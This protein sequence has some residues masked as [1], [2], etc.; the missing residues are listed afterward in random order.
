MSLFNKK[1]EL[2]DLL[3][4]FTIFFL[5][6]IPA[7]FSGGRNFYVHEI[8][9]L[10]V[11]GSALF[12][13]KDHEIYQKNKYIYFS[14]FIFIISLFISSYFSIS[15]RS[16]VVALLDYFDFSLI[17]SIAS[18]Y[19][20][21]EDK[22][23]RI[24]KLFLISSLFIAIIGFYYFLTGDF[25]RVTSTFYWP[26]PLAGYLLFVIPISLYLF[27]IKN[28]KLGLISFFVSILTLIFTGSRGAF[29]SLGIS[30]LLIILIQFFLSSKEKSRELFN[31]FKMSA[32]KNLKYILAGLLLTALVFICLLSYKNGL[33]F[34]DRYNKNTQVM[35]YSSS[36]RLNYWQ[37]AISIFKSQPLVGTGPNTYSIVYPKFQ[38]DILSSGKYAHNWL[39]EMLAEFGLLGVI[40][41][42]IFIFLIYY[43]YLKNNFSVLNS[44]I[45]IGITASI[46]HNLLDFD[47]HF[48]ANAYIFYFLLG[49]SINSSLFL[50]SE[51][52][53]VT[54]KI[55]QVNI[56]IKT[57]CLFLVIAIIIKSSLLILENFYFLKASEPIVWNSEGFIQENF[58]QSIKFNNPDYLRYYLQYLISTPVTNNI[59]EADQLS[60]DLLAKD[61]G[62]AFNYYLRA[63][64]LF[65]KGDYSAA[66]EYCKLAV[67]LDK[68]NYP[69]FYF[70]QALSDLK[71]SKVNNA[72]DIILNNLKYYT[73]EVLNDKKYVITNNQ[74]LE[75]NLSEKASSLYMLLANIYLNENNIVEAKK[76]AL[77]A[78]QIS[79]DSK[80]IQQFI[81]LNHF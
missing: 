79:P 22:I 42:I 52:R 48:Y 23:I 35:D 28:S 58:R 36:I 57:I 2:N 20:F 56:F 41:F 73:P 7:F 61:R 37:G 39:L 64:V 40:T 10:L 9:S 29:L 30:F 32:A 76:F 8:A 53:L 60:Q 25:D 24:F 63:E 78:R 15:V 31:I 5:L 21:N 44:W 59:Q 80:E 70:L 18:V 4:L 26:N 55:R 27:F 65:L 45:F 17:F 54:K 81:A 3:I 19:K 51:S 16:S 50:Q 6:S 12:L 46:L 47:W 68:V 1:Y 75:T 14:L 11:A 72:K 77:T 67:E 49:L 66:E 38:N 33:S 34:F 43:N 74:K 69:E 62:L 13:F 71:Q